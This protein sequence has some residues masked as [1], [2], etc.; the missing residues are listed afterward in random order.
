MADVY[1][2]LCIKQMADENL[3][4]STQCSVVTERAHVSA[5]LTHFAVQQKLATLECS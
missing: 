2:L 4:G 5:Q 3:L 1:T